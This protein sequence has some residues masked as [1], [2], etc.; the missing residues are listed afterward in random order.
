VK[1]EKDKK[2]KKN[3]FE[4]A[5]DLAGLD[6]GEAQPPSP[7]IWNVLKEAGQLPPWQMQ[8]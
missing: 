2:K 5:S 4:A 1:P 3:I 8:L 6:I 7:N